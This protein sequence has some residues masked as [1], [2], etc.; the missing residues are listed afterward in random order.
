[1]PTASCARAAARSAANAFAVAPRSSRTPAG[2]VSTARSSSSSHVLPAR[3][4]YQPWGGR[5]VRRVPRSAGGDGPARSPPPA[6]DRTR[7][8]SRSYPAATS[9][10]PRVGSTAPSVS[11]APRS[12][13]ATADASTSDTSYEPPPAAASRLTSESG[14]N[15]LH[16]ASTSAT[17]AST[18]ARAAP[19]AACAR[20]ASSPGRTTSRAVPPHSDHW[21]A[22][23]GGGRSAITSRRSGWGAGC[24][25]GGG[26]TAAGPAVARCWAAGSAWW[27]PSRSPWRSASP[28]PCGSRSWSAARLCRPLGSDP[29]PCCRPPPPSGHRSTWDAAV[30]ATVGGRSGEP[31]APVA[32][33]APA[34]DGS[35]LGEPGVR[36]PAPALRPAGAA[37]ADPDSGPA[38]ATVTAPVAAS[39]RAVVP[40]VAA[41]TRRTPRSR[42]RRAREPPAG[43]VRSPM[44]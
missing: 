3:R 2:T 17:T 34:A 35:G 42:R 33:D 43:R 40:A 31:A 26:W 12:A 36:D 18:S 7:A 4:P 19:S 28:T 11:R 9:A 39:A 27:W 13:A 32:V 38:T 15:R 10:C 21:S 29:V 5:L 8:M 20:T 24:G 16:A 22:T 14:R 23:S 6:D 30:G 44:S 1:M 37:A 41:S 25:S